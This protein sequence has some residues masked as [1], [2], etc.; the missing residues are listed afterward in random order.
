MSVA[1]CLLERNAY[2]FW[3]KDINAI[4]CLC[5]RTYWTIP[6]INNNNNRQNSP[7][8]DSNLHWEILPDC[9]RVSLI[10]IS[11]QLFFLTQQGRQPCVQPLTWRTGSL[12]LYHPGDR[13]APVIP[14][15]TGVPFRRILR[16][17]R[18]WLRCSAPPPP[19]DSW[20][21]ACEDS[22]M[23]QD[24]VPLRACENTAWTCR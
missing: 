10:W 11:Q 18:L 22:E 2:K 19:G 1:W 14:P 4:P 9:I 7:F 16:L 21:I 20:N 8:S 17:A 15:G 13:G 12:Y 24:R 3:P 5:L 6:L 23:A